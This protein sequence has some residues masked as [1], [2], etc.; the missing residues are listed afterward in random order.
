M[1]KRN[2]SR[3]KFMQTAAA[4]AATGLLSLKA[5]A[6]FE[7]KKKKKEP[8]PDPD[9]ILTNGHIHT[10]D[11]LAR[12]VSTVAIKDGRFLEVGSGARWPAGRA[13]TVI[14]LR[15][16]TVVPGIIDNHNHMVL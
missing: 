15:G 7:S 2:P 8:H 5:Q 10:M 3:R 12:V 4:A 14:D 16:K 6:K 9:V 11:N 13:T 1:S